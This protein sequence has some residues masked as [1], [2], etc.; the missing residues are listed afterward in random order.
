MMM[1]AFPDIRWQELSAFAKHHLIPAV[2]REMSKTARMTTVV[3][4]ASI[5]RSLCNFDAYG[6]HSFGLV[7][8][9][10]DGNFVAILAPVVIEHTTYT[11]TELKPAS[12]K[13]VL[14]LCTSRWQ[15]TSF[16]VGPEVFYVEGENQRTATMRYSRRYIYCVEGTTIA[17][18]DNK[19]T[20]TAELWE[21]ESQLLALA[22]FAAIQHDD[23]DVPQAI[24]VKLEEMRA[25]LV[26]LDAAVRQHCIDAKL[27]RTL[28]ARLTSAQEYLVLGTERLLGSDLTSPLSRSLTF[29][30]GVSYCPS[31]TQNPNLQNHLPSGTCGLST[32]PASGFILIPSATPV[33]NCPSSD[34]GT[35][36]TPATQTCVR[37]AAEPTT[38][39]I[40]WS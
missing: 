21:A 11:Q 29:S 36:A 28:M 22:D 7:R 25:E 2:D 16:D 40:I 18:D 5:V 4:S 10:K 26:R 33:T 39:H 15:T 37:H 13:V 38:R 14:R 19:A 8:K 12:A 20:T 32:S 24:G 27:R 1:S 34:G 3:L 9:D 35:Y 17:S 30:R 6:Q 23:D 31:L